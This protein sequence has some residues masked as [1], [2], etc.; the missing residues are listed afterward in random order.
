MEVQSKCVPGRVLWR[1]AVTPVVSSPVKSRIVDIPDGRLLDGPDDG[2]VGRRICA[3]GP[4]AETMLAEYGNA[5]QA[6]WQRR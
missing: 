1:C 6:Q 4:E 5:D 3:A 2:K